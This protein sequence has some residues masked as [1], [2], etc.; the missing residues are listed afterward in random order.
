MF[1]LVEAEAWQVGVYTPGG[2]YLPHYDA[3]EI[4]DPQ[5]HTPEG[6]WVGNRWLI[7]IT[8]IAIALQ[9]IVA[10][11]LFRIATV[12]FYLSELVGGATA[13]IKLGLAVKPKW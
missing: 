9:C 10:T 11:W 3:F 5:A 8:T 7:A 2:H 4:L 12:L 13:F 1:R 6:L